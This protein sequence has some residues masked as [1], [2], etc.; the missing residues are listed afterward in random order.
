MNNDLNT[1]S[2]LLAYLMEHIKDMASCDIEEKINYRG[3]KNYVYN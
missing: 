1:N 3:R 2:K